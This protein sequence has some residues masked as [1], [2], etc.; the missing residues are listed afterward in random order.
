MAVAKDAKATG[1]ARD[2]VRAVQLYKQGCDGGDAQGCGYLGVMYQNGTGVAKE[3]ARAAQ[4]FK[5][6]CESGDAAACTN[7]GLMHEH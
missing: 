2:A 1:V 4:L 5:Q 6:G 7:L 3:V